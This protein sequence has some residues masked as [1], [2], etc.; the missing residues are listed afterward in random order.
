M[1]ANIALPDPVKQA[2]IPRLWP[3]GMF[4]EPGSKLY[5][6]DVRLVVA[7]DADLQRYVNF[8]KGEDSNAVQYYTVS[9]CCC[10]CWPA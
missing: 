2:G 1:L 3:L 5:M 6:A 7:D 9:R 4:A 8:F 10:C